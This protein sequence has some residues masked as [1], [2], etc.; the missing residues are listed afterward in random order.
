MCIRDRPTVVPGMLGMGMSG[1]PNVTHDIGGFSG[2]PSTKELYFRWT[3][4]GA[5]TPIMRTHEG[6]ARDENWDWNG[7]E[8]TIQH[9]RRFTRIHDLLAPLFRQLADRAQTNSRPIVEHLML[10]F[11]EDRETWD[12]DDQFMIGPLLVAPITA[13]GQTARSVYLPEGQWFHVWSGEEFT[14]PARIDVDAPL[15]SPPVF[16]LG[17]DRA[18]LRAVE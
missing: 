1:Q 11:P 9:F 18:D 5:F 4:L 15:G 10:V 16:S 14:G 13:E 17:E 12:I 2:G 7:D 8:E 3:E 6:N